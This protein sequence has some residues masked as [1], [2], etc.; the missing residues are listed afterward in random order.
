MKLIN[1]T[2]LLT[3]QMA[4]CFAS[5]YITPYYRN[6]VFYYLPNKCMDNQVIVLLVDLAINLIFLMIV[7]GVMC[8]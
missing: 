1:I 4:M 7:V 8:I 3:L 5:N 6:V 2:L